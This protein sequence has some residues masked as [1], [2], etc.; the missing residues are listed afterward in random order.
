MI[1]SEAVT[2]GVDAGAPIG[3]GEAEESAFLAEQQ[4]A[5][6]PKAVANAPAETD[7]RAISLP[8][9]DELIQRIPAS[10]RD[11]MDQLFRARFITVK[12]MPGSAFKTQI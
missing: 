8:P 11:L 10:T 12:R 7:E 1:T 6:P 2:E 4:Q 3:P 9:M 5:N